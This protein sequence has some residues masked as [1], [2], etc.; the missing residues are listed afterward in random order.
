LTYWLSIKV[1]N[2]R[3]H[4]GTIVFGVRFRLPILF[5]GYAADLFGAANYV[6]LRL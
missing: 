5:Y 3:P 1:D 2:P 4:F 6:A